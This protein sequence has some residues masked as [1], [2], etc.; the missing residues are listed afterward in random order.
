MFF[1]LWVRAPR[2]EM[3]EDCGLATTPAGTTTERES[4]NFGIAKSAQQAPAGR[5]G[6]RPS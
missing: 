6:N 4:D 2:T 5:T 3:S 1:R